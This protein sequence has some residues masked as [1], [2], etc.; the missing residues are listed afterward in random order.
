VLT[1]HIILNEALAIEQIM[2]LKKHVRA[3]LKAENIQHATIEFE[4][5]HEE[6][7]FENCV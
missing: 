2:E 6:C 1:V 4:M 5:P 7:D 3:V